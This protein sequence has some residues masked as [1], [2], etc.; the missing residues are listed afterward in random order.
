MST[1]FGSFLGFTFDGVHSSELGI[2][3]TSTSDRYTENLTPEM[4][5]NIV[6]VPNGDG[7]YYF[8]SYYTKQ[9]FQIPFA[10]DDLSESQLLRLKSL[11]GQRGLHK[12][13][14]D[15]TPYKYYLVSVT[16][17]P[18][19]RYIAFEKE[20]DEQPSLITR[21]SDL[22]NGIDKDWYEGAFQ[23]K[24]NG[25]VYRG[26]GTLTC[27]CFTPYAKSTKKFKDQF[28]AHDLIDHDNYENYRQ[29]ADGS[30]FY[31]W[32]DS[33]RYLNSTYSEIR[34]VNG[35]ETTFFIDRPDLTGCLIYNPGMLETPFLF[36]MMA[37]LDSTGAVPE[38]ATIAPIKLLLNSSTF[39]DVDTITLN[40]GD[41]GVQINTKLHLIEGI[42]LAGKPTGTVY[43]NAIKAGNFFTIPCTPN[44]ILMYIT[45]TG[46]AT[47][48]NSIE[49]DYIFF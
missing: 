10:F 18:N 41:A 34:T 28:V 15:E 13:V 48:L 9:T 11:F 33:L 3:R 5:D 37:F 43:N 25:R 29:G 21:K 6:Q 1:F 4:Q 39:I 12:L 40:P 38:N 42:D 7:S 46:T 31:E 14:F 16:G 44:P 17:V 26:D 24:M 32:I 8:G 2:V 23:V 45:I 20:P 30:D 36:K 49:Y 35:T 19:L 47:T 22:Y 27:T